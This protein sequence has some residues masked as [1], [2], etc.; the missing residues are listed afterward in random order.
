MEVEFQTKGDK[1]RA[2]MKAN[3]NATM[4]QFVQDTGLVNA[5]YYN[6]NKRLAGRAN[7]A[8]KRA[9]PA[10]VRNAYLRQKRSE[11]LNDA[12]HAPARNARKAH[13]STMSVEQ[14]ANMAQVVARYD[15]P[16]GQAIV[17]Y[18]SLYPDNT[19]DDAKA[20]FGAEHIKTQYYVIRKELF[21]AMGI[22]PVRKPVTTY[23]KR[24]KEK[25][26]DMD[27][28][29]A[30]LA[31]A[32]SLVPTEPEPRGR[33]QHTYMPGPVLEKLMADAGVSLSSQKKQVGG[34]HY[35]KKAIQPWEAIEAWVQSVGFE[36]Y[37]HGNII[38]YVARYPDK[39]GVED[40]KKAAHYIERL[41]E[42]L[43]RCK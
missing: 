39:G 14:V 21:E 4:R 3:P 38:K 18:T 33:S 10:S 29:A 40:L 30:I 23:K 13:V 34:D 17:E 9:Q 20:F 12:K 16:L 22:T 26:S 36:A 24:L 1:A 35:T 37:L 8:K 31:A 11:L 5:W 41:V 28:D 25:A 19:I 27:L 32:D 15:S 2:Y 6:V 43:E 42:H 7:A